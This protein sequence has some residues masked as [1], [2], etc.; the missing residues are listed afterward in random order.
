MAP[1]CVSKLSMYCSSIAFAC[2]LLAKGIVSGCEATGGIN[3]EGAS[4][5]RLCE[6][7]YQHEPLPYNQPGLCQGGRLLNGPLPGHGPDRP[8][9]LPRPL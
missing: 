1:S 4:S 6:Y 2:S 3:V 5:G 9:P 7:R 8:L